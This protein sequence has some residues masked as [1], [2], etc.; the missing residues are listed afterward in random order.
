MRVEVRF[1]ASL[2][3]AAGCPGVS[4]DLSEGADYAQLCRALDGR[5]GAAAVEALRATN[6][7]V[8]RNQTLEE[9]PFTLCDGDEV[10]FLPPVTG[11]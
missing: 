3:D 8:A 5:L 1:F 6:V 9:P 2:K 10:A 11:G 7:R 4:L